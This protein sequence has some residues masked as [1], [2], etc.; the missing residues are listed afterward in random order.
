[1]LFGAS[2]EKTDKVVGESQD[3]QPPESQ[4]NDECCGEQDEA[5]DS[6]GSD[7]DSCQQAPGHG[8]YGANDYPGAD[9]VTVP[10]PTLAVGDDCPDCQQGTLYE[11]TPS[12]LVRFVGRSPL[13]ATVYR[14]QKLRRHLCGKI[15]TAGGTG[16]R[17]SRQVRSHRGQHDWPAEVWKWV[18]LQPSQRLQGNC[19]IPLAA[20]ILH[21]AWHRHAAASPL[22]SAY[23]ELIRQ[24]AQGE[25]LYNDDTTVKILEL[26][27]QRLAKSPPED[28]PQL[29]DRTGL[30]TSG[31]VATR[32]ASGLPLFFSGRHTQ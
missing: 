2:S 19:E 18:T 29:P 5:S 1:M 16:E 27:G 17:W 32:R 9:Q 30:F 13:Q 7:E 6:T 12:V 21:G 31:V 3:V 22:M 14:M 28:D 23:E 4:P 24:A 11:K 20:S 26:M 10:H 8:R 15:F 25:V